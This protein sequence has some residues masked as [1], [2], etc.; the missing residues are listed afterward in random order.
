MQEASKAKTVG[1]TARLTGFEDKKYAHGVLLSG[2][3]YQLVIFRVQK[4]RGR[5]LL[6]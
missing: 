2:R 4:I 5:R 3:F 1:R 6:I